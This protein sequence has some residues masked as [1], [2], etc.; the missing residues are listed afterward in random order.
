[1]SEKNGE[2]TVLRQRRRH[3]PNDC[4]SGELTTRCLGLASSYSIQKACER[5]RKGAVGAKVDARD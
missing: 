1:M 3:L 4:Y 5:F 2:A